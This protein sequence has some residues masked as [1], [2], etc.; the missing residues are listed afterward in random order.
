M[1]FWRKCF[2]SGFHVRSTPL[3]WQPVKGSLKLLTMSR[4]EMEYWKSSCYYLLQPNAETLHLRE[5]C[6]HSTHRYEF[7]CQGHT[8]IWSVGSLSRQRGLVFLR[9][10]IFD[11]SFLTLPEII[12]NY[13]KLLKIISIQ[14]KLSKIIGI[15]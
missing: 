12:S 11:Q 3:V 6:N 2:F 4:N 10:P 13:Q 14:K 5:N 9:R 8:N 7:L 1:N 15:F